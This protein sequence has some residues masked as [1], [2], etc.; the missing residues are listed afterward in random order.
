CRERESHRG[1]V[2]LSEHERRIEL[3]DELLATSLCAAR[4]TEH[5]R[6]HPCRDQDLSEG[7]LAC[8]SHGHSLAP[9]RVRRKRLVAAA[10]HCPSVRSAG[11]PLRRDAVS[12]CTPCRDDN[13]PI[14]PRGI[15]RL[16]E[17]QR[18]E[19]R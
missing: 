6:L 9:S 10:G 8:P 5:R 4:V 7:P 14:P 2:L 17:P 1:R 3:H 19:S 13:G 12:P 16:I 15:D 11:S 18:L